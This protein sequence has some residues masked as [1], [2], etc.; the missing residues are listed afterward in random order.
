MRLEK[1]LLIRSVATL[2]L[3]SRRRVVRAKVFKIGQKSVNR[4]FLAMPVL[5]LLSACAE[6]NGTYGAGPPGAD[7]DYYNGYYDGAYGPFYDGY[8]GDDGFFWYSDVGRNWHRDEGHHFA[9]TAGHG[10]SHV[11]GSGSPRLH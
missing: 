8:W 5:L 2:H 6:D 3:N 11:H 9:H 7:V 1:A 4:T 10:F